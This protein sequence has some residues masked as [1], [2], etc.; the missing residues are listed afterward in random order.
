MGEGVSS[1][2]AGQL[3]HLLDQRVG[4]PVTKVDVSDLG[5]VDWGD[6]DVLVLVSGATGAFSGSS[7][8]ALKSWIRGG[9]TLVAQKSAAAWAARNGLTP[10]I[11][12]PGMGRPV[13]EEVGGEEAVRRDYK[14]AG[15]FEGPMEIGGSIW[16]ADLDFTHPLGFG[17]QRRFLPVW[18][19]HS[20]FFAPSSNAY[21]TVAR[22]VE[23]DPYLSGY[24]SDDNR[25][26]LRGS[27]SVM[28]DRFGGGVV[29]LLIDNTNFR[30][31][32][33]GTNRLF[34]NALFFGNHI[35]VP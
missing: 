32:W 9:G 11:A 2:E 35:Q 29:V 26:R 16:E 7:L 21:S 25:A 5:R 1:Y 6:F 34:L 23:D 3:W 14:D 31:Y 18:R 4:M 10:N 22:L 8:D 24:I 13:S 33:R 17:Y 27:P 15:E 30:G 20:T 28:A 12:A 19:D